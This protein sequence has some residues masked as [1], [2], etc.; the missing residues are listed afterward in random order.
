MFNLAH[1]INPVK[2]DPCRDLFI[3]QPITFETM[4]IAKDR[5]GPEIAVALY[6]AFF[7]EDEEIVPPFIQKTRV[8]ERSVLDRE[9]LKIGPKLPLIRDI[10]DRLYQESSAEYFIYTNVDI[11]LQ[12]DFYTR[13]RELIASGLDGFVINRR[14]ISRRHTRIEEIPLMYEEAKRGEKHPGFD[15]FVFLRQAYESFFLGDGCVGANWIGRI[16]VS[17]I[18]AFSSS[19]RVFQDFH[20]TFHLG[21]E[22]IWLNRE[23]RPLEMHNEKE[24]ISV[25]NTLLQKEGIKNRDLLEPFYKYHLRRF[26]SQGRPS[27]NL[28]PNSPSYQLPD[29]PAKIYP[30]ALESGLPG[31]EGHRMLRQDPIFV[32]GYPRSGTTFV[33]ALIATQDNIISVPETHFFSRA[34]KALTVKREKVMP[35]CL[36]GVIRIIRSGLPLSVNAESHLRETTELSPKMLFETIITDNI[37][38]QIDYRELNNIRWVEKTPH[39]IFHLEKIFR[40]YPRAKIIYVMRNPEKAI[41]S[42]RHSFIFNE[43]SRWPIRKHVRQWLAGIRRFE[44]FRELKPDS[45]ILIRF[46]DLVENR[47]REM[48]R[49][50][51]FLGLPLDT[52][53]L[54]DYREVAR[55][56][57]NPWELWKS[58]LT[59]TLPAEKI[60]RGR[61]RL[62]P[63]EQLDL[64]RMAGEKMREYGYPML[65]PETS[66][67]QWGDHKMKNSIL[68]LRLIEDKVLKKLPSPLRRYLQK[69][70]RGVPR[71]RGG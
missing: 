71:P 51:V 47:D 63:P 8:L 17:N 19:F 36:D 35:G 7:P 10:L 52:G 1:I 38:T 16:L 34:W 62:S 5:A 65:R 64:W 39:H 53:K 26:F 41:I 49:L 11:A 56:L 69:V 18:A 45:L 4:R 27:D 13:I 59:R 33:Q 14:T 43:E 50:C 20:L 32:V 44:S 12:P 60:L 68:E 23:A 58:D 61:D 66:I 9:D 28:K 46:E 25:L 2:V 40:F 54:A 21:D 67:R 37:I 30:S 15:C 70:S 57:I 22:R 29:E 55:R 31:G 24:L 42:R 48:E 6:A 3:A